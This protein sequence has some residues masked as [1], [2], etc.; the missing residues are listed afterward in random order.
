LKSVLVAAVQTHVVEVAADSCPDTTALEHT[1]DLGC[2]EQRGWVDYA[3]VKGRLGHVGLQH[4]YFC[5]TDWD[6]SA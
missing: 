5:K 4:C 2:M 6:G 1:P 3:A